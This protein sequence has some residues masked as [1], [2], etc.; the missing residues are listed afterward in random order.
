MKTTNEYEE[1]LVAK[2]D[3]SHGRW[4]ENCNSYVNHCD[5]DNC[6]EC[7]TDGTKE[8]DLDQKTTIG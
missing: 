3:E 7:G 5:C 1:H 8:G 4:C 2:F 6:A